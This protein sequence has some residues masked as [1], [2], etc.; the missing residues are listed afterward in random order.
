MD[1]LLQELE[2]AVDVSL[3]TDLSQEIVNI[4]DRSHGYTHELK[5]FKSQAVTFRWRP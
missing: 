1:S 4:I 5:H 2:N 3:E